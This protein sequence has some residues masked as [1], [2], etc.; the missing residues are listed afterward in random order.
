MFFD[1]L[2]IVYTPGRILEQT[3]YYPFGLTMSGISS[4]ALSFGDPKNKLGITGK[5]KQ[6]KEFSDGSGLEMY[7]FGARFDDPQIGRWHAIDPH[8]SN[9]VSWTPYNYVGNSPVNMVDLDGKD[10]FQ[11]KDGNIIWNNSRDKTYTQDKV[12]YTN[13]GA[14][15]NVVVDSYIKEENDVGLP[16][17]AGDKLTNTFT[18]TGNYNKDGNFTGFTTDFNRVTGESFG[19]IPGIDGVEGEPNQAGYMKQL[20]DGSWTGGFEQHTTTNPGVSAGMYVAHGRLVDVNQNLRITVGK[21]GKLTAYVMHGTYP[22]VD[23]TVNGSAQYQFREHSF[24]LSHSKSTDPSSFWYWPPNVLTGKEVQA[25][26]DAQNLINRS[27]QAPYIIFS[28]FSSA[29]V[30]PK[31]YSNIP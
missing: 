27:K 10:W 1:N 11:D 18:V 13:I 5:E 15:L 7:D 24:M 26:S 29:P 23:L 28:G 19:V 20:S 6:D 17:T 16:G 12:E 21:D 3:H 25:Q 30:N 9:Y 22:S 14:S 31:T 2:Q 8:A 4:K